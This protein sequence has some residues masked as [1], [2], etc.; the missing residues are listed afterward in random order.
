MLEI[1]QGY[2]FVSKLVVI[3]TDVIVKRMLRFIQTYDDCYLIRDG[4]QV[5][6]NKETLSLF[7]IQFNLKQLI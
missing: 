6:L 7:P 2:A 1:P 4:E 3:A 5:P